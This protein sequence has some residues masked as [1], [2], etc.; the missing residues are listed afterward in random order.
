MSLGNCSFDNILIYT[1]RSTDSFLSLAS[2][3]RVF[4]VE[5]NKEEC[6]KSSTWRELYA[7]EFALKSFCFSLEN[8]HVKWFTDNQAAAKIVEVGS[9]RIDLHCIALRIFQLCIE[10]KI[11]LEIQWV[12]RTEVQKADFI[13]RL[14]D[15]DDWQITSALFQELDTLW[16]SHSVDCF[17]NHYNFKTARFFSSFWNPGCAGI[18][19]FIQPI[20]KE[21]CLVVPPVCVISRA[22]HYMHDQRAIGT[23]V[24]P[25]WP[26]ASFWPLIIN[27]YAHYIVG[28]RVFNGT[29]GLEHGRNVNSLLG[30]ERFK[31]SILAVRVDFTRVRDI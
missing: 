16:G 11:F 18:D 24:V 31:G 6:A 26:S 29:H 19:F 28:Y 3:F 14:I 5:L 23:V 27:M 13:S 10:H 2:N 25:F 9:M 7:I 8:S 17:A 15:I 12:P 30:S 21:N 4:F 20:H 1:V 22:F